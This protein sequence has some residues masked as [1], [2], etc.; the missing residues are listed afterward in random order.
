[1]T[2]LEVQVGSTITNGFYC[3]RV[4][5]RVEDN[6]SGPGWFGV[7]ITMDGS[8]DDT[9]LSAYVADYLLSGWYHVPFE[10]RTV[11]GGTQ[12]ERYV[13]TPDYRRL[14]REVRPRPFEVG[15]RV[16]FR[17]DNGG[18]EGVGIV[19]RAEPGKVWVETL[20]N[21]W[22]GAYPAWFVRTDEPLPPGLEEDEEDQR[23][24]RQTVQPT[25]DG[26]RGNPMISVVHDDPELL[27]ALTAAT[28]LAPL[29]FPG[30]SCDQQE[31]HDPHRWQELH[32]PT[33]NP[34]VEHTQWWQ[35]GNPNAAGQ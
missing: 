17:D 19:R 10:W 6:L 8:G 13:W 35:C 16:K 9:G 28:P 31:D 30:K 26:I 12:E 29:T 5:E 20:F 23:E 25:V 1:V 14:Q 22:R 33:G 11:I 32:I 4:T 2:A 7:A 27:A 21:M 18:G 24:V 34:L 15:E 3:V